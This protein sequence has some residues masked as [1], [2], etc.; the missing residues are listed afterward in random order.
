MDNDVL[1]VALS[2]LDLKLTRV[3]FDLTFITDR[4]GFYE[5]VLAIVLKDGRPH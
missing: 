5:T 2:G 1:D 4:I 3:R